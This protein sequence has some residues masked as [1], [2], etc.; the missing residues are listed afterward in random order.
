MIHGRGPSTTR[1]ST[2][3]AAPFPASRF[4]GVIITLSPEAS[5]PEVTVTPSSDWT[6]SLHHPLGRMQSH[7]IQLSYRFHLDDTGA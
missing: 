7:T 4:S 1:C 2:L 3:F 5:A 6:T